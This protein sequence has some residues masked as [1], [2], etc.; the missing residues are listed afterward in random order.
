MALSRSLCPCCAM[1]ESTR[2]NR[3]REAPRRR[4]RGAS[5]AG[6]RP[7]GARGHDNLPFGDDEADGAPADVARP[8]ADRFDSGGRLGAA[9][10]AGRAGPAAG[11]LAGLAALA[12][13]LRRAPARP[14]RGGA[15]RPA[16]RGRHVPGREPG[17][18]WSAPT[19]TRRTSPASSAPTT[20]RRGTAVGARAG[21]HAA[22]AAARRHRSGFV[23]FDGE[24]C[25]R[26]TPDR[27][28]RQRAACA[29]ASVAAAR[30]RDARGHGLLDF[31]GRPR[32]L[33]CRARARRTRR[34]G[35]S[36]APRPGGRAS[37]RRFPP[38]H[39]RRGRSTTTCRSSRRACRRST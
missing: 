14:L 23:L 7:G 39:A 31:V 24:E 15:R 9:A 25:P 32:P 18:S 20:A 33:A 3:F 29:A 30:Y 13:R 28:L 11:R 35:R 2:H 34:S 37:A 1:R 4:A 8:K 16:Q 17:D 6:T 36:C 21:A 5:A 12:R 27:R 26:G 22:A 10:R 38:E 19:T